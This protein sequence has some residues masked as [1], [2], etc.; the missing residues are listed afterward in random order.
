MNARPGKHPKLLAWLRSVL[1]LFEYPCSD[2]ISFFPHYMLQ[3]RLFILTIITL[4]PT[5]L[6]AQ[7]FERGYL[8]R[9]YGDTLR[10]ELENGFWEEAPTS[11]R[12]RTSATAGIQTW[13]TRSLQ[14]FG[15]SSGRTWRA[16]LLTYDAAAE[17]RR[18]F[19]R[20]DA[21]RTNLVTDTLL[22]EVL[23]DG[24]VGLSAAFQG[25]TPHFFV[26]RS[27]QPPLELV[28][29]LYLRTNTEGRQML[30]A[31]NDFREQLRHYLHPECP[32]VAQRLSRLR[33]EAGPLRDYLS[34]YA[35]ACLGQS[36]GV[37]QVATA[38]PTT[39]GSGLRLEAGV[40][41]GG[42]FTSSRFTNPSDAVLTLAEPSSPTQA[43]EQ[44][45]LERPYLNNQ[46]LEQSVRPVVGGYLDV[47]FPGRRF[48]IH[49]EGQIRSRSSYTATFSTGQ[50]AYPTKTYMFGSALV[51]T[52]GLGFR[53]M[54]PIALGQL[55]AGAGAAAQ[56]TSALSPRIEFPG[57]AAR[58]FQGKT[59]PDIRVLET[60]QTQL[61]PYLEVGYRRG[62]LTGTVNWRYFSDFARD[63]STIR[64][65]V[66]TSSDN[67][68]LSVNTTTYRYRTQQVQLQ[69]AYR[70]NRNTDQ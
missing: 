36:E 44:A 39:T 45:A 19:V 25:S 51:P 34:A 54:R 70:L 41:L 10:G 5:F 33:F 58:Q 18:D 53:V 57:G 65:V 46:S 16:Q 3:K 2:N 43:I 68:L 32:A 42:V 24:A 31:V 23:L 35:A 15:F 22:T 30:S 66:Y 64:S 67:T 50:P 8:V 37:A 28:S 29:R 4:W 38:Q 20:P 17:S 12:F 61:G 59:L 9:G 52:V 7:R 56:L 49:A 60:T 55:L 63:L 11:L 69:V 27:G 6:L 26:Q 40:F 14:G 21:P 13:P 47:L 62:R 1:L 48:A